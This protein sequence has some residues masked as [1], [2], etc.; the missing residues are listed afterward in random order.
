VAP[1][2]PR[3]RGTTGAA[4]PGRA[5]HGACLSLPRL[6]PLLYLKRV[7][8]PVPLGETTVGGAVASRADEWSSA[9]QVTYLVL[10]GGTTEV[11][12]ARR[13]VFTVH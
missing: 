8:I 3:V 11:T 12:P 9:V 5:A 13:T 6:G 7:P 10:L 2:T 1:T 4:R